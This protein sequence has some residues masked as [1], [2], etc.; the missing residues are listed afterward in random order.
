[1]WFDLFPSFSGHKGKAGSTSNNDKVFI[2]CIAKLLFFLLKCAISLMH[3][4]RHRICHGHG[5]WHINTIVAVSD[6]RTRLIWGVSVLH[7]KLNM[8]ISIV[9]L[10]CF[11]HVMT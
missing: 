1:M 9:L 5:H 8:V 4:H 3:R 2:H 11:Y 7:I 10:F 6:N